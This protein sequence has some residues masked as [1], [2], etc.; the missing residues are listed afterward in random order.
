MVQCLTTLLATAATVAAQ[1]MRIST[2]AE[3]KVCFGTLLPGAMNTLVTTACGASP[4][5][6]VRTS[7][8]DA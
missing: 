2:C 7:A 6:M 8:A 4:D 3:G 5:Y 1:S